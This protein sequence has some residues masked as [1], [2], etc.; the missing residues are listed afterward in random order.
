MSLSSKSNFIGLEMDPI[1][2]K[3]R[4]ISMAAFVGNPD[5]I[6]S[7]LLNWTLEIGHWA[8]DIN[9]QL[10][11]DMSEQK[12]FCNLFEDFTSFRL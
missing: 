1:V 10:L 8:L 6:R 5:F 3:G 4:I 2:M 12:D 9:L 7:P 11:K